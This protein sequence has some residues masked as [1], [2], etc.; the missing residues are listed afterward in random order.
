MK[1][2]LMWKYLTPANELLEIYFL[3]AAKIGKIRLK[4]P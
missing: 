1:M 3:F 4:L 2:Y